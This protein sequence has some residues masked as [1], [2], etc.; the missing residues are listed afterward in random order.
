MIKKQVANDNGFD[1]YYVWSD[2][3]L[4]T[5]LELLKRIIYEKT[6]NDV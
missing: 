5:E 1:V 6:Q 2:S 4:K 3:N